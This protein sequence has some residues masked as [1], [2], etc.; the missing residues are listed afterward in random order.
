MVIVG[1]V[2]V[3]EVEGK[4]GGRVVSVGV[5]MVRWIGG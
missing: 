1:A 4:R 2:A 5:D 3:D